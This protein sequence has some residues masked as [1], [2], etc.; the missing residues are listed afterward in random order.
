MYHRLALIYIHSKRK[1]A[2]AQHRLARLWSLHK[3]SYEVVFLA[4]DAYSFKIGDRKNVPI[5]IPNKEDRNFVYMH[6]H[7]CGRENNMER[8]IY[9]PRVVLLMS[10]LDAEAMS[11]KNIIQFSSP[12]FVRNYPGCCAIA[13]V[14]SIFHVIGG[15]DYIM[16]CNA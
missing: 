15:Y 3:F 11:M 4:P 14:W 10:R 6:M 1:R 9:V 5:S 16:T 7:M 12:P 8:G 13:R 2:T